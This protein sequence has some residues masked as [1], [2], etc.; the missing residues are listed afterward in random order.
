MIKKINVYQFFVVFIGVV[1]AYY[2]S[3]LAGQDN[4]SVAYQA[5]VVAFISIVVWLF[6]WHINE[7]I[8]KINN[9]KLME[10]YEFE[11]QLEGLWLEHYEMDGADNSGYC[12]IE[13]IYDEESKSLHLKG[14]V[15][16]NEGE[17]FA[18]WT[19]KSVYL[20]R[21]TKSIL[22]IYDGEFKTSRLV[23]NGYG[24]LDFSTSNTNIS[25]SGSGCFEDSFTEYK[26][27]NF[28]IDKLDEKLSQRIGGS[29]LPKRSFEKRDFVKAYHKYLVEKGCSESGK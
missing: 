8:D 4:L 6:S 28:E 25:V 1:S 20:D 23:G 26:P 3:K 29:Q 22:Y 21:N 15:Y 19:S 7:T 5:I 14:N 24:K 9:A 2:V 10:R 16:N 11:K 17:S 18:N 27:V 13:I 12:L